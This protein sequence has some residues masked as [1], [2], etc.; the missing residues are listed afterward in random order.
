MGRV[1]A[2]L[3]G[4]LPPSVLSCAVLARLLPLSPGWSATL[5]GLAALPVWATTMTAWFW[6][7]RAA[8]AWLAALVATLVL[9]SLLWILGPPP[10]AR[11]PKVDLVV[12]PS[13]A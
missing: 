2:A 1:L 5:A 6:W 11:A 3:V 10:R 13:E 8:T 9:G 4:T 12:T 7:R